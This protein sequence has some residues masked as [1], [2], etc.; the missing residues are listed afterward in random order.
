MPV[1]LRTFHSGTVALAGTKNGQLRLA[2]KPGGQLLAV[3]PAQ[4][5]QVFPGGFSGAVKERRQNDKRQQHDP[6]QRQRNGNIQNGQPQR[7][8]HNH[9]KRAHYRGDHPQVKVVQ[10]V[11]I[12]NDT[13]Q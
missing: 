13:V 1:Q 6:A 4:P 2:L 9:H 12:R 7:N 8:Y 3:I 5:R 10:R 11:D